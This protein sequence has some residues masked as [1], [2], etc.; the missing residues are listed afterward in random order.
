MLVKLFLKCMAVVVLSLYGVASSASAA[1][2]S[3]NAN[4]GLQA[5]V[6]LSDAHIGATLNSLVGFAGT[7][8]AKS[9]SWS[10]IE[11][12]LRAATHGNVPETVFYADPSGKYWV[13]GKGAQ[14]LPIGDRPYFA[15]VFTGK[16]A[17]G[18][19]VIG[20]STGAAVAIVAVPVRGENGT[21]TGLVGAAI[22]LSQLNAMLVR[23][24]GLSSG[25]LFWATDAHGITAL[26]SDKANI[27]NNALKDPFIAKTL[28]KMI[29]TPSGQETYKFRN[30][31][32]TVLYRH[33][34]LTGWTY[35]F[36]IIH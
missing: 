5:F 20:R 22:D 25:M 6:S 19:L 36:G 4:V 30:I 1:P 34:S 2:L 18:D 17:V 26:H 10:T 3:I 33:S 16:N 27:M 28:R 29:A 24:L 32:R 35:G 13:V 31:T 23:E 11:G 8:E 21:V 15:K 14:A 9:G 12:G 7:A